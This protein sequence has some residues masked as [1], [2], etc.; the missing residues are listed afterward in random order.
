MS[1]CKSMGHSLGIEVR[2][3]STCRS[4]FSPVIWVPGIKLRL[5]GLVANA[6][7]LSHLACYFFFFFFF[8]I[9]FY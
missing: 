7:S 9:V 5:S 2:K 8:G 3:Q 4:Q 1:V 6:Y